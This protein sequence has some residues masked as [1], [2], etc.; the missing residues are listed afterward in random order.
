MKSVFLLGV[1]L[2]FCGLTASS[3]E[4][5][6]SSESIS[7][8]MPP[9]SS[10]EEAEAVSDFSLR[11]G[12]DGT[13]SL[14]VSSANDPL[15][16]PAVSD[17]MQTDSASSWYRKGWIGKVYKYFS[18]SNED[19]TLTRKFDYS[20]IGG[21]HYSSDT[22]LGIGLI[23]A[24][25]YRLDREDLTLPPS[26]V[27]LFGDFSTS[28]FYMLG[29]RGNNF[30]KGGRFRIDYTT[31]FYSMPSDFWGVGYYNGRDSAEAR[32]D[33]QQM[34]FKVDLMYRFAKSWYVG[35]NANYNF[36]RGKHI[37]RM[38]YVPAGQDTKYINTGVGLFLQHDSRDI[39]TN[40]YSGWY[41]K[42]D[43]AFY[44]EWLGNRDGLFTR[45]ELTADYYTQLAEGSVLAADLHG[46]FHTGD[47]P[48]TM[49]CLMGGGSRM[50]GYYDG[51]Y[52][53]KNLIE[54]Q[55][56]LRQHVYKR[57]GAAFWVGAAQIFPE[58]SAMR[59]SHILPNYGLGLRWEFK[60]RVNIRVD[61]G[62]GRDTSGLV[63]NINEAF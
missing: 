31:Y 4:V 16:Q 56:E 54:G 63:F 7:L 36:T 29:I 22:E 49:L 62:F 21:P 59:W 30:F 25:L 13:P 26:N 50:R 48:W 55:V 52:R 12:A 3:A 27:T 34:K 41:L 47:V 18:E 60:N 37:T 15:L 10:A 33:R 35:F 46:M 2:L 51:R 39:V 1:G 8:S 32:M 17:S 43:Q 5:A 23:A 11:G 9:A 57:F 28:G 6:S 14:A 44:P 45:T 40:P 38:D 19:K 58:F 42:I 61:Y 20:I 53:D 24:G